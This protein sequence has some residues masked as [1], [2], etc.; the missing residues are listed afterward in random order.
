MMTIKSSQNYAF[1]TKD[2]KSFYKNNGDLT[3]RTVEAALFDK[4]AIDDLKSFL[5]FFDID[6]DEVIL[7]EVQ[8]IVRPEDLPF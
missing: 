6:R 2:K 5:S 3:T 7:V 1:M 4:M 8:I